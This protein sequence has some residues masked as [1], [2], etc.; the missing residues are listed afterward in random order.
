[1]RDDELKGWLDDRLILNASIKGRTISLRPGQI[2][3]C[4]PFGVATYLTT[5]KVR[6]LVIRELR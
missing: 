3:Q 1:V 2:E 5:G 6:G 4:T